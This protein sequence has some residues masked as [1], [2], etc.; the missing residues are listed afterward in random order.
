LRIDYDKWV[1]FNANIVY[2]VTRK[3][4]GRIEPVMS[5]S[6]GQKYVIIVASI[7]GGVVLLAGLY[8]VVLTLTT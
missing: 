2:I 7:I 6:S 5:E 4:F 3:K 1:W 8:G